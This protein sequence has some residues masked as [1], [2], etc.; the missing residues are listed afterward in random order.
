[1]LNFAAMAALRSGGDDQLGSE[2]RSLALVRAVVSDFEPA[3]EDPLVPPR[4]RRR[5]ERARAFIAAKPEANRSLEEIAAAAACSPFHLVRLFR[6]QTGMT[7]RGYRLRLRL[8]TVLQDLADGSTDLTESALRAG[9][10]DHSHMTT[11]FRRIFGCTPS[12]LREE[13]G[14]GGLRKRSKF[15]QAASEKQA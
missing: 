5:V 11:S 9:F 15:L 8:A 7:I 13:L 10:S 6:R 1:M 4:A 12:A 2:E 3:R 14:T